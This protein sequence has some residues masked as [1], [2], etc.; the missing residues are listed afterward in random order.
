MPC[1]ARVADEATM[2]MSWR[3]RKDSRNWGTDIRTGQAGGGGENRPE[4]IP[5]KDMARFRSR[6]V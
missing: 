5:L 2:G 4:M 3:G 1:P 6:E